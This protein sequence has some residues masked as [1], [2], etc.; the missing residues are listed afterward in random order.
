M[1]KKIAK[2]SHKKTQGLMLKCISLTLCG[3][4]SLWILSLHFSG[5]GEFLTLEGKRVFDYLFNKFKNLLKKKGFDAKFKLSD[6]GGI[7]QIKCS[8]SS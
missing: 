8:V 4:H 3:V 5:T 7:Y 2:Y 1:Y 6:F